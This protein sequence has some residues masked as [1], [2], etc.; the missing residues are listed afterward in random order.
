LVNHVSV[1]AMMSKDLV[2]GTFLKYTSGISIK[3]SIMIVGYG[4]SLKNLVV[5]T[6]LGFNDFYKMSYMT[7]QNFGRL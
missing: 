1:T 3:Y 4:I 5:L 2:I 7:C 6:V